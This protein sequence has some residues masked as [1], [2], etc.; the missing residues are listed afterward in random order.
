MRLV[1]AALDV[2]AMAFRQVVAASLQR[3]SRLSVKRGHDRHARG[4][5]R[6]EEAADE[7]DRKREQD[8][9]CDQSR[10]EL[11]TEHDLREAR[12]ERRGREPVKDEERG[13]GPD[14]S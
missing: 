11:E 10:R 14:D 9:L 2:Q 4:P 1:D 7:A 5:D 6:R 13:Q 3:W 12:T 8:A